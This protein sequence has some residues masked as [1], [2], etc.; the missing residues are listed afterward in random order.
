MNSAWLGRL[1]ARFFVELL[2]CERRLGSLICDA[3][4]KL[5]IVDNFLVFGQIEDLT[6]LPDFQLQA[7]VHNDK[8][9]CRIK[10]DAM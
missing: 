2:C 3:I 6:M 7:H 9:Y 1:W 5:P 10:D 4:C 8:D